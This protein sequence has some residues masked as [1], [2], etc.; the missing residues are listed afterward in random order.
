MRERLPKRVVS[1]GQ[2]GV[3]RAAL[4]V[5][6]ELGLPCGGWCPK[7]RLAED[8]VI[9]KRYPLVE[10]PSDE[11]AQRTEWNVRDSDGTLILSRGGILK[12]GSALTASLAARYGRPC[13]TVDLTAPPDPAAIRDWIARNQVRTLNVAGPRAGDSPGLYEQ[14]ARVLHELLAS[15]QPARDTEP[16]TSDTS[17]ETP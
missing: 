17:A 2:T 7:G 16:R 14:A 9:P 15:Q 1:G 6:L 11:Y 5:A 10:T 3:D 8:G 4:E 12:G 13:L